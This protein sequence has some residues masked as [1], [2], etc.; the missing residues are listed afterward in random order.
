MPTRIAAI[1]CANGLGH[2]KRLLRMI[3]GLR[4]AAPGLSFTLFCEQWQL[5]R[6]RGWRWL[7]GVEIA[8]VSLPVKWYDTPDR[9]GDWLND[10]RGSLA[11]W[12]LGEYDA[13]IADNL[14]EPLEYTE[15]VFL[16]GSFLW[17][18]VLHG[19][20]PDVPTIRRY[21]EWAELLLRT[22][23][24][25]MLVNRYF[26]MPA[27]ERLTQS[28]KIDFISFYDGP[29]VKRSKSTPERV[30]LALGSSPA[31]SGLVDQVRAIMLQMA[32]VGIVLFVSERWHDAL[33]G[34]YPSLE[35]YDFTQNPLHTVDAAIIRAGIGSISDCIAARVPAYFVDDSNPEIAFNAARLSELGIGA[36]LSVNGLT[37]PGVYGT[38]AR[39]LGEFSANG[40]ADATAFLV[41]HWR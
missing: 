40:V 37:T 4:E 28:H 18:D 31:A 9:Y 23:H 15:N 11:S 35:R 34:E 32:E 20:Y 22:R 16:S 21:Y 8:P 17:H 14:V 19:A 26:A 2:I 12:Q 29:Q 3:G 5:D 10:W 30:L 36:P 13:V 39:R 38:I 6:L 1:A 33:A 41:P 25:P 7:N 27:T 24:P